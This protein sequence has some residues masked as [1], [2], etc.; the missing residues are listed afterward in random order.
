MSRYNEEINNK[1]IN[2]PTEP[3]KSKEPER[4]LAKPGEYSAID[5]EKAAK[6][7]SGIGGKY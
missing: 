2:K 4:I 7:Y 1:E 6:I 5:L 3:K